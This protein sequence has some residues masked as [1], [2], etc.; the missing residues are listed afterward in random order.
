[1]IHLM[2]IVFT[3]FATIFTVIRITVKQIKYLLPS[4]NV[5]TQSKNTFLTKIIIHTICNNLN[6]HHIIS[7]KQNNQFFKYF[8]H[9]INQ[10]QLGVSQSHP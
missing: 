7:T 9:S 4:K 6:K 1:M 8:H 3:H 10:Y 5:K 2:P